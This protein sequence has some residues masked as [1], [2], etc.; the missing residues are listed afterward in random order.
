CVNRLTPT[1]YPATLQTV[2]IFLISLPQLPTPVGAQIKLIAFSGAPGTTQ[3]PSNP[4]LLVNQTATI[5]SLPASGAFID[6]P[7]QNG[8]TIN[9]G[10]FY[11]GFQAPNPAGG[12]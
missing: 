3:P 6:F 11:V 10:D 5:P 8:P 9:S 4:T 1:A 12:V 7:I 2:R